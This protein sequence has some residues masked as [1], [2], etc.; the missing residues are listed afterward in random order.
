M[1]RSTLFAAI[2]MLAA[3][4]TPPQPATAQT[5]TRGAALYAQHC[6]GCHAAN[7]RNDPHRPWGVRLGAGDPQM[8]A[9]SF[10]V[11]AMAPIKSRLSFPG[12]AND[13]AAYL[14]SVLAAPTTAPAGRLVL[15]SAT[16]FDDAIVATAG[17]S[18]A[19][20]LGNGGSAGLDI[21]RIASSNA[22]EFAITVDGCSATR[23]GAGASCTIAIAFSPAAPGPRSATITVTTDGG[24]QAFAVYGQG[25]VALP[26]P[27]APSAPTAL[28]VE[29]VHGGTGH[30][31]L[32]AARAEIA[33]LDAGAVAGW[34]RTGF[35]FNVYA[36]QVPGTTA[37]CRY[38][39]A[40]FPPASSH[41]YS[42][43]DE[44]CATLAG[45]PEW[46]FEGEVFATLRPASDG[47][48]PADTQAVYRLYNNGRSGAPNHRYTV[49]PDVRMQMI[50]A[51]HAPE[52]TGGGVSW[53]VP[54]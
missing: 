15:P 22:A 5:A 49:D 40:A 29:Y 27:P 7:P 6:T 10:D 18:R 44:E 17:T 19:F 53:C 25:T 30:Y 13:L 12:D 4:G 23:L 37:T 46:T 2:L 36:S 26:G 45:S 11:P 39:T 42:A 16:T 48:C 24:A 35:A 28:A 14:A 47:S 38:F 50:A 3:V 9:R 51:G 52:G 34:Q 8:V 43:S 1:S 21:T 41:F 32:T 20:T 31:F 54:R 33:A